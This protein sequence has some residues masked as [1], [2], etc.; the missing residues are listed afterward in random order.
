MVFAK[1]GSYV[2]YTFNYK[3]AL[4]PSLTVGGTSSYPRPPSL[5]P[6]LSFAFALLTV[7]PPPLLPFHLI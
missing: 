6:S 7:P 1:D 2:D 4:E 5:F 3:N